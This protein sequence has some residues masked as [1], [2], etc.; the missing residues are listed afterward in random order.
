[1]TGSNG[2]AG[3]QKSL[4]LGPNGRGSVGSTLK[5]GVNGPGGSPAATTIVK[6]IQAGARSPGQPQ[7]NAGG[8]SRSGGDVQHAA[9]A[10]W[11]DGRSG[12]RYGLSLGRIIAI[13]I[14]TDMVVGAG[15]AAGTANVLAEGGKRLFRGGDVA[16]LERLADGLKILADGAGGIKKIL[17]ARLGGF[18]NVGLQ[19]GKGL[20]GPGEIAGM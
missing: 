8:E 15:R 17:P 19:G 5:S 20:R 4:L 6:I 3:T 7:P 16:R 1:M 9:T 14:L 11:V 12:V 2:Q 13:A 18:L 10:G